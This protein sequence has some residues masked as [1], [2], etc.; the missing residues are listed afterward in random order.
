M[1]KILS[2][3]LGTL[4][5]S[6]TSLQVSACEYNHVVKEDPDLEIHINTKEEEKWLKNMIIDFLYS[7]PLEFQPSVNRSY[8]NWMCTKEYSI[9]L[10][11]LRNKIQIQ[12]TDPDSKNKYSIEY[13][14]VYMKKTKIKNYYVTNWN[15]HKFNPW[16]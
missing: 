13:W 3:A 4:I 15:K 8:I 2:L 10:K 9:D 16:N 6:G 7:L 14:D 11:T 1:K 5:F 12:S